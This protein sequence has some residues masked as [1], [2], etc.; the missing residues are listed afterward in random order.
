MRICPGRNFLRSWLA[1]TTSKCQMAIDTNNARV[2][3]CSSKSIELK[4]IVKRVKPFG[5]VVIDLPYDVEIKP[6]CPHEYP[7][8]DTVLVK[9]VSQ[10]SL[11]DKKE[12]LVSV[13]VKDDACEIRSNQ[14]VLGNV[15]CLVQTPVRYDVEVKTVGDANVE[16]HNMISDF[17]TVETEYGNILS[18]K[19]QGKKITLSSSEGGSVTVQKSIQGEI[20]INTAKEGFVDAEKCLG[21][22]LDVSTEN[23]FVKLGS[24]YCEKA[25]FTTLDGDLNL[26]NLHMDNSIDINGKGSL[27]ISCFDGS[28]QATLGEGQARIQLARITK[29]SSITSN[30]D[31]SLTI[32][33]TLDS[34]LILKSPTLEIDDSIQGTHNREKNEFVG[35]KEGPRFIVESTRMIQVEQS[36]WMETFKLKNTPK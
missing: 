13:T 29:D 24:N 2:K 20:E 23:G 26:N 21:T 9:L 8:M 11:L 22:K 25:T 3:F 15:K 28:L 36:S 5:R 16:V 33:D 32:P 1:L 31:I 30:G 18:S 7:D 12:D 6:T 27:N 17:I 14:E 34:R 10:D 4:N 19:L 35:I